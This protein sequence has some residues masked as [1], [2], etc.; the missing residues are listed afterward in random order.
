MKINSMKSNL[1]LYFGSRLS[2]F[3]LLDDTKEVVVSARAVDRLDIQKN[4][5]SL[6]FL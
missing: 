3:V 4:F 1:N 2:S 5:K 6:V